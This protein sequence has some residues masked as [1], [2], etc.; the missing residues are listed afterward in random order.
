LPSSGT[1]FRA[2]NR[3][4]DLQSR[5]EEMK[6]GEHVLQTLR[7][8]QQRS[9]HPRG[10]IPRLVPPPPGGRPRRRE[11]I[12]RGSRLL[13]LQQPWMSLLPTQIAHRH[14]EDV[15]WTSSTGYADIQRMSKE[16]SSDILWISIRLSQL[17]TFIG[18]PKYI[19]TCTC[20][21]VLWMSIGGLSQHCI[22]LYIIQNSVIEH[23]R[24]FMYNHRSS[25][26][27][28]RLY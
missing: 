24:T 10:N 17:C 11:E 25:K 19:L 13:L 20:S 27:Y 26:I 21:D 2:Q 16:S 14:S 6:G 23:V 4:P 22:Y 5:G 3:C 7:R 12:G 9:R 15:H 1:A 28:Y 18:C 8:R